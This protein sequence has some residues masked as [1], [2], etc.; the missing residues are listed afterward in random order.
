MVLFGMS[1]SAF[2]RLMPIDQKQDNSDQEHTA[3]PT[4]NGAHGSLTMLL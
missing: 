3:P 4:I 1:A 2:S